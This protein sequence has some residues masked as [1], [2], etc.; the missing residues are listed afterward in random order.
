MWTPAYFSAEQLIITSRKA[1]D[2]RVSS[3]NGEL[4]ITFLIP[5]PSADQLPHCCLAP[6]GGDVVGRL[7]AAP[8][9]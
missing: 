4:K 9:Q 6:P 5:P 1:P 3:N 8:R 2:V 7:E